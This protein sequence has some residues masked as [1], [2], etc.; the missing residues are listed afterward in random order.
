MDSTVG[1]LLADP[2]V[3][4]IVERHLGSMS[5]NPM[6]IMMKRKKMRDVMGKIRKQVSAEKIAMIEK[7]ILEL[8]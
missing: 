1:E 6:I 8:E 7:E 3:V 4:E 2:R 5:K